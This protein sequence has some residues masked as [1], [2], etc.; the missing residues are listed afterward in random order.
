MATEEKSVSP[1]S[2]VVSGRREG[3]GLRE[4]NWFPPGARFPAAPA[5]H[6]FFLPPRAATQ[7]VPFRGGGGARAGPGRGCEWAAAGGWE[8]VGSPPLG[9]FATAGR[10]KRLGLGY[11]RPTPGTQ[12][13]CFFC[14]GARD[15]VKARLPERQ[16][17]SPP[18]HLP[19]VRNSGWLV[20]QSYF[21]S[22]IFLTPDLRPPGS[23]TKTV[24]GCE[25]L[26]TRPVWL[27]QPGRPTSAQ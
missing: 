24:R 18:P 9:L 22:I 10:H 15:P 21:G 1:A 12:S 25:C 4:V 14:R 19:A 13:H 6:L 3:T 17:L 20:F 11:R 5:D 26:G 23:I 27:P 8:R 16:H 7:R 2:A